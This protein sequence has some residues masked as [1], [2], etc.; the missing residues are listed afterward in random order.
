[1]DQQA[2]SGADR[3]RRRGSAEGANSPAET[4]APSAERALNASVAE[5]GEPRVDAALKLLRQLPGLPLAE[6][7]AVFERVHSELS[8]VLGEL[9]PESADSDR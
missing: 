8:N 9:D 5:T 3:A 2:G 7:A 4:D 1:M 6:H